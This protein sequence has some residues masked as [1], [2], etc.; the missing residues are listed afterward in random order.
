MSAFEPNSRHLREVLIFCFHLKKITAEAH[1]MLSS[2]YGEAALSERM[3]REWFQR[4]KSGDLTSK[5]GMAVEERKF[6]KIP[7]WRH[8]LMKTR[9]KRK[10]NWQN[11]WEWLNKLFRNASKPW[12]WFRSKGIVFRTSWRREILNGVFVFMN[13]CFKDRIGRGFYIALW[14]AMKNGSI[15]IIPSAENL[16]E[17]PDMPPR[18]RP[19]RIFTVPRSCSAFGGTSSV[20]CIMSCWNRVKPSQGIG[21]ECSWC[22]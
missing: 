4:F 14:P 9:A 6:S 3:C 12:E 15:T 20:W 10:K 5:T 16:G 21:I 17:C 18:R 13:S 1:R 22:V 2:T 11:H 7:N 19:D 8:Y